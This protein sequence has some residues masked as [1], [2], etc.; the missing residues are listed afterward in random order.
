MALLAVIIPAAAVAQSGKEEASVQAEGSI[1]PEA[2]AKKASRAHEEGRR[3]EERG[4]WAKAF[5]KYAEALGYAPGM[6]RYLEARERARFRMVQEHM[7]RAEREALAGRVREAREELLAALG[8]DPSF[9]VAAERLSQIERSAQQR[10]AQA[11][12]METRKEVAVLRPAAGVKSFDFRGNTQGA[13]EE[14]A[15]QCGL[16]VT[17]DRE[18]ATRNLRFRVADVD[19]FT[20]LRLLGQQTSTFWRALSEKMF[21]VASDTPQKRKEYEPTITRTLQLPAASSAEEL[22]EI[23]QM[24]REIAGIQNPQ[25]DTRTRQ[26][27]VSGTPAAVALAAELIREVDQA[28]GEIVLEVQLL[29]LDRED[30]RRLGITPPMKAQTFTLSPSDIREA[31]SSPEGLLRVISRVFGTS[32][33]VAALG[34]LPAGT[35]TF[36]PAG[37]IPPLIAIGG[38][39]SIVLATLPGAAADFAQTL[40]VLRGA[41]RVLLRA[42]DGL[43]AT[44]F[45]GE[46]FPVSLG[47]LTPST[48]APVIVPGIRQFELD[49]GEEPVAVV[50]GDFDSTNGLDIAVANRASDTVS[51]FLNTGSGNF[52]ARSDLATDDAPRALLARDFDGDGRQDLAVAHAGANTLAV[53]LGNGDGTFTVSASF[54]TGEAPAAIVSGDFNG[55]NRADLVVANEG[56][57]DV[58][59]FPGNG[60]GTFGTGVN[61]ATGAGPRALATADF[62][63]D[64]KADLAVA[65][66]GA[67]TISILLGD[68]AG[69][70]TAAPVLDSGDT[71]SALAVGDLDADGDTDLVA[72]NQG[73]NSVSIFLGNGDGTFAAATEFPAGAQPTAVVARDFTGDG[74]LDLVIGNS[75][76]AVITVLAGEGNGEFVAGADVGLSAAAFALAAGDV[77]GDGRIDVVTANPE[78]NTSIVVI[79]SV[80]GGRGGTT[81]PAFGQ[82]YP[83]ALYEDLGL[84]VKATPRLHPNREVTLKLLVELKALGATDFNGI[85]MIQSHSF[86]QMVRLREGETTY[87]TGVFSEEDTRSLSGWPWLA[88]ASAAGTLAGRRDRQKRGVEL[89]M[90]ITPHRVRTPGRRGRSYYAGKLSDTGTSGQS[91]PPQN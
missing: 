81:L 15:R 21:L 56:S 34:Q 91:Q 65:N 49:T 36:N 74:N 53:L 69:G 72:T 29:Q 87:L 39:R 14:I 79:N 11:R 83:A 58:T 33:S 20:A 75:R 76:S 13:Y 52:G 16:T 18:M 55:D 90:A 64:G 40:R 44:F 46:R 66:S 30:S 37:L 57:N 85:P 4:E 89:V 10:A 8:L 24:L 2:D 60:D 26:V 62:N 71:P 73:D 78:A 45:V 42:S 9:G 28:R 19:C 41:R 77:N 50:L 54:P 17:F 22:N 51:I 5:L 25:V 6:R 7:D 32:G 31:Q 86:E 59:F 84:K 43:E 70:F 35:G 82:P 67:A 61:L 48:I 38:G 12:E 27:T 23:R 1:W 68:G 47:V 63:G 3:A 88:S 80:A